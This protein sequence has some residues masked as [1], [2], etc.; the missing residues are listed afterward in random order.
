MSLPGVAMTTCFPLSRS[1]LY[2]YLGAPP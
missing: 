2:L 1:P